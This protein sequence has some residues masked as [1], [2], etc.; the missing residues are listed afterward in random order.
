MLTIAIRDLQSYFRTPLAYVVLAG[1]LTLA[2]FFFFTMLGNFN[3]VMLQASMNPTLQPSLNEW[4]ITPYYKTLEVILL[5]LIPILTMRSISEE[6]REGTFELLAT[7]PISVTKIVWGKFLGVSSTL[8]LM[9]LAS[10]IFPLSVIAF[11][12]PE[13]AP[14]ITGF[15][16]IVF[17]SSIFTALGIAI[18]AFTKHQTVAGV[19]SLVLFLLLYVIHGA[20]EKLGSL[21]ST[22]FNYLSPSTH[23]EMIYLGVL[24][25]SSLAYFISV[26]AFGLF[27]ATRAL[28]AERWR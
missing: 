10:F 16:G 4:V 24:S 1:F 26:I 9:L 23:T 3:T 8:F 22:I 15:L 6:K 17:F 2:G 19:V 14:T 11:A 13:I 18:S 28:A 7:S 27:V 25:S 5:F 12:D 20:G 21:A